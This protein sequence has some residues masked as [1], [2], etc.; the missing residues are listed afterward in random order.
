VY[1][2]ICVQYRVGAETAQAGTDKEISISNMK[3]PII[4]I[5][6]QTFDISLLLSSISGHV[7]IEV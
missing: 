1:T 7:D 4:D 6:A 5:E 3:N 2:A